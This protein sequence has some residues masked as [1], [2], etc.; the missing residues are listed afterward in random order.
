MNFLLSNNDILGTGNA[1]EDYEQQE[2]H[3]QQNSFSLTVTDFWGRRDHADMTRQFGHD[4]WCIGKEVD[5]GL[6][7]V[8]MVQTRVTL[9]RAKRRPLCPQVILYTTVKLYPWSRVHH[10]EC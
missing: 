8:G 9:C 5:H 4:P 1:T 2:A 7:I 10:P 3:F 6:G